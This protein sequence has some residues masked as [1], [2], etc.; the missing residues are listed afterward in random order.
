[1]AASQV[2]HFAHKKGMSVAENLARIKEILG[3]RPVK[4]V[5]VTKNADPAQIEEAFQ[6]GVTEFGENRL[7][8]ALRKREQLPPY[9]EEH[10][11]WHFVGH[12]QMNKVRQTIGRFVLVHS[13]DSLK[14]AN[15][16]SKAASNMSVVQSILLQVKVLADPAKTGF[17]I[18]ELQSQFAEIKNLP[19]LSVKGL[20]TMTPLT[21]D[22]VVWRRCFNGLKELRDDLMAAH[23][24]KLDELSMGMTHDWQEAVNCGSTMIRLGRA[25]FG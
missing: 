20:M 9:V 16:L 8:D 6:S 19:N 10:V 24:V 2:M 4:L 14:L 3:A 12:L 1:V 13:V 22:R 11:N 7:Q 5:A 18:E 15:E 17:T 23:K 21:D 25:I